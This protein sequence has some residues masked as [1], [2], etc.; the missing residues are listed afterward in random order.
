[1]ISSCGGLYVGS[2]QIMSKINYETKKVWKGWEMIPN[3]R[4]KS[5]VDHHLPPNDIHAE[6]RR[7]IRKLLIIYIVSYSKCN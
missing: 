2:F 4:K 3:T 7:D 5:Q 1:M 6:K